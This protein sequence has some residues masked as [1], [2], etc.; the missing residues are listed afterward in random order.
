MATTRA[1]LADLVTEGF[2]EIYFNRIAQEKPV[3]PI[4]FRDIS[5][6]AKEKKFSALAGLGLVQETDEG[7]SITYD[8]VQQAY[9]TTVTQKSWRLAT[10]ITQ[11]MFDDDL[12]Q[13]LTL[14]KVANSF[15][16]SVVATKETQM[17]NVFNNAFA[18]GAAYLGGD[19]KALCATDHPFTDGGTEQNELTTAADLTPTS[20]AEAIRTMKD[21]KDRRGV[22]PVTLMPKYLLVPTALETAAA[23]IL[24]SEKQAYTADNT[25]NVLREEGL[26]IIVW[27]YLSDDDAWFV[28]SEQDQTGLINMVA[29]KMR[30]KIEDDF[31]TES[32]KIK[33]FYREVPD[34]VDWYGTFGSPGA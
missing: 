11:E 7:D 28:V 19:S 6:K 14:P 12:Y 29:S 16:R 34:F 18:A 31:N 2:Q 30:M 26:Q 27:R 1:T 5:I 15:A 25:T 17:A 33:V 21:T 24:K 23:E 3:G 22:Y 20:L 10:K 32:A 13:V 8:D 9:D 4:F